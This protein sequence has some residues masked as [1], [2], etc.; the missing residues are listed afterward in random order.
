MKHFMMLCMTLAALFTLTVQHSNAQ[1][2][3]P[4]A[5]AK[6]GS[7]ILVKPQQSIDGNVNPADLYIAAPEGTPVLCPE[8]G[9]IQHFS[10]GWKT[11]FTRA[12]SCGSNGGSFNKMMKE[13]TEEDDSF[14]VPVNYV[15][16]SI[17]IKLS[18]NRVL[19]LTGLMGDVPMKTG[20]TIHRGDTLGYVTYAVV[21]LES[22]HMGISLSTNGKKDDVMKYLGLESTF[23]P[24]KKMEKPTHLTQ[25]QAQEDILVLKQALEEL[26]PSM[27]EIVTPVQW[28][29]F[30][31]DAEE[32]IKAGMSYTDFYNQIA[33]RSVSAELVHDTHVSIQ[34]EAPDEAERLYK[35]TMHLGIVND[36]LI[37]AQ[38]LLGKETYLK[39]AIAEID[40]E[41][42]EAIIARVRIQHTEYDVDNKSVCFERE[43]SIDQLVYGDFSKPR[44][45]KIVFKDGS[46]YTDKW[47]SRDSNNKYTPI[48]GAEVGRIKLAFD[49][50][51]PV[52]YFMKKLNE[53]TGLLSITR[54]RM[55]QVELDQ[56][57]K[58]L[59]EWEN[60][61]NLII[62]C[63]MNPGGDVEVVDTLLSYFIQQPSVAL[64]QYS[65]VNS[66][67]TYKSFG[68][69]LNYA[70]D[71]APFSNYKPVE[72]KEGFYFE[73][74][75]TK[76]IR[77]SAKAS[78]K[79]KIAVLTNGS[80]ISAATTF[81]ALLVKNNRAVTVGRETGSA[82]HFMSAI[83]FAEIILPNSQIQLRIPLVKDV[84]DDEVSE[85]FPYGRGLLPDYEVPDSYEE[86]YVS[87]EDLILKKALEVLQ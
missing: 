58:T 17:S 84:F 69:A 52:N 6:P 73:S 70:P 65:K 80:S 11:L 47:I 46:T 79:G 81:P 50:V 72:N 26:Y 85:R 61:P 31:K 49:R 78:Y 53:K 68:H 37:A 64:H 28:N 35:S 23:V 43:Q 16:G 7:S 59:R 41:K 67:S 83:K 8:D 27:D 24:G 56:I 74:N 10:L 87:K 82:Y 25:V 51:K 13:A 86:Y 19:N 38:V 36:E 4:I 55:S 60:V 9:T 22:P 14:P 48:I 62:D 12:S 39:K 76:V 33:K 42:A 32:R 77:P 15:S 40:G 54:F 34:T 71:M 18:G 1:A 44:E 66:N 21:L 20:Q 45:V 30:W 3:W 29:A 2:L 5:G 63:R 75:L 57:A